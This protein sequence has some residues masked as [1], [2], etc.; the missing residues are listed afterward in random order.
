[1]N[2]PA[3]VLL[4]AAD[5][6]KS[7]GGVQA[8]RG[9]NLEVRSGEVVG[10]VGPN[11]AG[12]TTLVDI[13]TGTQSADGGRLTLAGRRLNG[14]A[15]RRARAGLG[16][17]FQHPLL[18]LDLT[19]T[20]NILVGVAARKLGTPWGMVA[21]VFDGMV[22]GVVAAD[23]HRAVAAAHVMGLERLDRP[24]ADLTLG[25]QRLVEVAR[26]LVQEP[27]VVLFDEPF[28]GADANGVAGI[29]A[30]VEKVRDEGRGAIL[31]DHNVDL[32][33][34]LA[35]RVVVLDQGSVGFSGT[36]DECLASEEMQRIY[37]VGEVSREGVYEQ[38]G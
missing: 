16:R 2:P 18:A 34:S 13:I 8:V 14:S 27:R 3:D 32:V 24:C 38:R 12:K 30:V 17:T 35:D 37:F 23:V 20:E 36:P 22:R 1:M 31:V 19:V 9:V 6:T 28:A 26:V 15:A 11:G 5:L 10:L 7:Y 21:A 29:S 25:E 4:A 33:S